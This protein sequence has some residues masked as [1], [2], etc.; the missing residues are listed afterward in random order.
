MFE[1]LSIT[2]SCVVIQ[3]VIFTSR[4]VRFA[5][6]LFSPWPITFTF[7]GLIRDWFLSCTMEPISGHVSMTE[8]HKLTICNHL[9]CLLCNQA[10][11]LRANFMCLPFQLRD[12]NLPIRCTAEPVHYKRYRSRREANRTPRL[13]KM[14]F[15]SIPIILL[16]HSTIGLTKNK[17]ITKNDCKRRY[18]E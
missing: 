9:Y 4:G 11:F 3:L 6:L 1:E 18:P 15:T 17:N 5:S 8:T 13:V 16:V 12:I 10:G 14:K 2:S 7:R